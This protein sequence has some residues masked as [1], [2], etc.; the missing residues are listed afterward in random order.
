MAKSWGARIVGR[1]F[2]SRLHKNAHA[3]GVETPNLEDPVKD[4]LLQHASEPYEELPA[5][6]SKTGLDQFEPDA[7][8]EAALTK[9][10]TK[11]Q[12]NVGE[13][14]NLEMPTLSVEPATPLSNSAPMQKPSPVRVPKSQNGRLPDKASGVG[15]GTPTGKTSDGQSVVSN[16]RR[17]QKPDHGAQRKVANE[18]PAK[19]NIKAPT[20]V[21]PE[22]L[23]DEII[24][25]K[26]TAKANKPSPHVDLL[27]V[28]QGREKKSATPKAELS[29]IKRSRSQKPKVMDEQVTD[30]ELAKLEA[31]NARL[32]LL[33]REK[34]K[35]NA[36][37]S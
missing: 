6:D 15:E 37:Q 14:D 12:M 20:D 36:L 28:V 26:V 30:E 13:P 27:K 11:A 5:K 16:R 2:G 29:P 31:E 21:K 10:D 9:G 22:N 19:A 17:K 7:S 24:S 1:L 4:S 3:V 35:S 23:T 25:T 18:V 34:L 33:L 32:K 8:E